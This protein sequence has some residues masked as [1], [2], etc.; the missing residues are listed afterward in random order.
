MTDPQ[1]IE[2]H[3]T[4]TLSLSSLEQQGDAS[5]ISVLVSV[6]W[7]PH[8][9]IYAEPISWR[10]MDFKRHPK[11]G[12]FVTS[13]GPRHRVGGRNSTHPTD[14]LMWLATQQNYSPE[15][16]QQ[17]LN[18]DEEFKGAWLYAMA[19]NE[20]DRGWANRRAL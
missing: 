19:E 17:I 16:L 7:S 13:E 15:H 10:V 6:Q 20:A 3:E 9:G 12:Q 1:F 18:E 8:D 14:M 5:T 11:T 4:M 2:K